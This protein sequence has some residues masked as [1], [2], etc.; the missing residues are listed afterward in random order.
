MKITANLIIR[1]DESTLE[2]CL[3]SIRPHVDTIIIVDTGSTDGSPEIAKKYADKWELYTECNDPETGLIVDFS[4]PRNR[5][6]DLTD[7]ESGVLWVDGDDTTEISTDLRKHITDD[8]PTRVMADYHYEFDA[9]GRC[10]NLHVRERLVYP[11]KDWRWEC[12]V[13]EVLVC[14][15]TPTPKTV[16]DEALSV[17]HHRHESTTP[18]EL[19]RNLRIL[20]EHAKTA[21]NDP[22]TLFYLGQ[23]CKGSGQLGEA[24]EAFERY[25]NFSEWTDE[26]CLAQLGIAECYEMIGHLQQA[27]D[28]YQKASL[29]KSWPD[30]LL[31]MGRCFFAIAQREPAKADY[32]YRRCAH[33][34]RLGLNLASEGHGASLLFRDPT[35]QIKI[36]E[37]YNYALAAMG[38]LDGA[39]E[40]CRIFLGDYPEHEGT[41]KNLSYLVAH[42][43]RAQIAEQLEFARLR[44]EDSSRVQAIITG[45]Y[46][47]PEAE[48]PALDLPETKSGCL[49]IAMFL[50][51]A[52]ENWTPDTLMATGMGGSET[53]AWEL[54]RR[55]VKLGHRVIMYSQCA[56][57]QQ[58]VYEGVG[59]LRFQHFHDLTCDVLITS[60]RPDAVDAPNIKAKATLLW[61]HDVHCG[62]TLTLERDAKID[63]ILGLSDWHVGFLQ[64]TYPRTD[65]KKIVATRNGIDLD[66]FKIDGIT[67]EP[68][69]CIYSSSPDRGLYTLLQLWPRIKDQ[70]PD[71]TLHVYYGFENWEKANIERGDKPNQ[72]LAREI[73]R[74]MSEA[75]GVTY[76]GR[77]DQKELAA[78]MLASGV[79]TYPTWFAETS[80]ITAMEAQAAG[81][82][83]VTSPIAALAETAR[84]GCLIPGDWTSPTEPPEGYADKF[85]AEVL[86][87]MDFSQ[88]CYEAERFCLDALAQEWSG[89]LADLVMEMETDVLPKFHEVNHAAG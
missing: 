19:G 5:A 50:G 8:E 52:W 81:L 58:G 3:E 17:I 41:A 34:I 56:A 30:P 12:P 6:L 42:R 53:M 76:H 10:N 39:I 85:V 67:R 71:A 24:I 66:R 74:M 63:R 13:H 48:V 68:K 83:M 38:D 29:T 78:A 44:P 16:Y 35:L 18:G 89:M 59:Y 2:A 43:A 36:H 60:R 23:E 79:W 65:P 55:L 51:P 11:A 64:H 69:R 62:D 45:E 70:E 73:R 86:A 20:R 32:N 75:D 46:F 28:W 15:T 61:V 88:P 7:P 22:R 57:D 80:C 49:D 84:N 72:H 54:S 37:E 1:D 77:V 4:K 21:G 47:D 25:L 82:W 87:R 33:W 26:R 9:Q 40:S 31:L 27:I 14:H